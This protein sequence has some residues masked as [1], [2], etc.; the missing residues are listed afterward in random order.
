MPLRS[1]VRGARVGAVGLCLFLTACGS[2][3]DRGR[4]APVSQAT[5]LDQH[6][7]SLQQ[8]AALKRYLVK[9]GD[10]LFK[11]AFEQGLDDDDLA[12]WNGVSAQSALRAG[13]SLLLEAP[14]APIRDAGT[15]RSRNVQVAVPQSMAPVVKKVLPVASGWTW[16]VQGQV[17]RG[18]DRQRGR[19]GLDIVANEGAPVRAAAAGEVVY[20]GNGLRGYG[21]LIIIKHNPSTLSAYAHQASLNVRE[22]Q[23]VLRGQPIGEIGKTDAERVMLHFQIR[24]FGKPVDPRTYLPT[25]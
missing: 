1:P 21:N 9:P 16:P 13:Q 5:T 12:A 24:E 14:T 4:G 17:W 6:R 10:T 2:A 8:S 11:I 23:H 3:P 25:T 20:A 18:F 15:S 22:G 19:K 7:G